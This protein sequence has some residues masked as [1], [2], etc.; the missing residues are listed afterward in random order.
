MCGMLLYRDV[1]LE[2]INAINVTRNNVYYCNYIIFR[3]GLY[4][5]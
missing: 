4:A 5:S 2:R 1:T 3:D